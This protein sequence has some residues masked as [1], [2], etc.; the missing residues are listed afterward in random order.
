TW[1]VDDEKCIRCGICV[2][3]CPKKSLSIE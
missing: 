3:K 2:D 1:A